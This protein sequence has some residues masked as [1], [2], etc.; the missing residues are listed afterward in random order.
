MSFWL[1]W[2]LEARQNVREVYSTW[3][4][5]KSKCLDN[6]T[7]TRMGEHQVHSLLVCTLML[8]TV[9]SQ[10]KQTLEKRVS[11]MEEELKVSPC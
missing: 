11:D 3:I 4:R 1:F 6:L 8:F 7:F 5:E 10:E 2:L 9:H